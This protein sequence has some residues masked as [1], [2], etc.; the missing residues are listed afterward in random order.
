[1]P[2]GEPMIEREVTVP[3]TPERVW[4]SLTGPEG[5]PGPLGDRVELDPRPGGEVSIT[6]GDRELQGE[7]LEALPPR[8]LALRWSDGG[9][10]SLVEIDLEQVAGGTRVSVTERL[11]EPVAM[12]NVI[13]IDVPLTASE[14]PLMLAVA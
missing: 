5:G 7:V 12:P 14:Q 2:D 6:D 1:M 9:V 13:V 10:D 3:A 4:E 11:L 8:R